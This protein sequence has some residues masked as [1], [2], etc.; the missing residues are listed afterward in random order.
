M[1]FFFTCKFFDVF[2][3][4]IN[5]EIA[6]KKKKKKN[7]KKNKKKVQKASELFSKTNFFARK[8]KK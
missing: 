3:N 8:H 6:K 1:T 2:R 4:L 7:K 5:R